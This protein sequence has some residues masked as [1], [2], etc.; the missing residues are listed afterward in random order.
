MRNKCIFKFGLVCTQTVRSLLYEFQMTES[1]WYSLFAV[2][3]YVVLYDAW[4]VKITVTGHCKNHCHTQKND[5][6]QLWRL[7]CCSTDDQYQKHLISHCNRQQ[8]KQVS[9]KAGTTCSLRYRHST[10]TLHTSEFCVNKTTSAC[11]KM[12]EHT[13][14]ASV[15]SLGSN[16]ALSSDKKNPVPFTRH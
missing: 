14:C 5:C 3:L 7:S 16:W 13:S 11:A 4:Q 8:W 10:S 15:L 12:I 1:E 9:S 2:T 6:L